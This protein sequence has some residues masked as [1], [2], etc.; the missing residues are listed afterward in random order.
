M[1]RSGRATS[2]GGRAAGHSLVCP[3]GAL[4]TGQRAV[5]TTVAVAAPN[6]LGRSAASAIVDRPAK[7]PGWPSP[8]WPGRIK[9]LQFCVPRRWIIMIGL[10]RR[11]R[12]GL[13]SVFGAASWAHFWRRPLCAALGGRCDRNERKTGRSLPAT[14]GALRAWPA[15]PSDDGGCLFSPPARRRHCFI[16]KRHKS[17]RFVRD[18]QRRRR[19]QGRRGLVMQHRTLELSLVARQYLPDR[20][21]GS[22]RL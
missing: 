18:V 6:S 11:R 17:A 20:L 5:W 12:R 9:W 10:G 16:C 3:S 1:P 4:S 7:S 15:A 8:L 14:A 22:P 19:R 13:V 2:T 21:A